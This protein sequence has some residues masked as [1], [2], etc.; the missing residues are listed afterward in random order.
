MTLN[1]PESAIEFKSVLDL[2][3]DEYLAVHTKEAKEKIEKEILSGLGIPE[4]LLS[5]DG[6]GTYAGEYAY[7]GK[8]PGDPN[9]FTVSPDGYRRKY[10]KQYNTEWKKLDKLPDEYDYRDHWINRC[11]VCGDYVPP[12]ESEIGKLGKAPTCEKCEK[13]MAT[14]VIDHVPVDHLKANL[15]LFRRASHIWHVYNNYLDNM[16][17]APQGNN[18]F[19]ERQ[20]F[21]VSMPIRDLASG[22][23]YG[24]KAHNVSHGNK[25]KRIRDG[26]A[27]YSTHAEYHCT[28][29]LR[30][31][32]EVEANK[33][34]F[35]L[36]LEENFPRWHVVCDPV[37]S[38][39]N[40]TCEISVCFDQELGLQEKIALA[41]KMVAENERRLRELERIEAVKKAK[42]ERNKPDPKRFEPP[43]RSII[44]LE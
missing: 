2:K 32:I 29:W 13:K 37:K 3:K 6:Y 1:K 8:Y 17:V 43:K 11:K 20:G 35:V 25:E 12:R 15:R 7:A 36:V 10:I 34:P 28:Q 21:T 44:D 42:E 33:G 40:L 9:A 31:R 26:V 18:R 24:Y 23:S 4:H 5:G 39:Y 38:C 16:I 30:N 19:F 27:S 41:E 22:I 14:Y